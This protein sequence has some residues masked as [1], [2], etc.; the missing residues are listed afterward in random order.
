MATK[1]KQNT[2]E[3]TTIEQIENRLDRIE[4]RREELSLERALL[5]AEA[6]Y[7]SARIDWCVRP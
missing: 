3:P 5:K 7:L 4:A 6:A 1:K 2:N